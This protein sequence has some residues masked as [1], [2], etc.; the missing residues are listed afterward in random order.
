MKNVK[1]LLATGKELRDAL[2]EKCE[3]RLREE[4]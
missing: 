3:R 2:K 4:K 1:E